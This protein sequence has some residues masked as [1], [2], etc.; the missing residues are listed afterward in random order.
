MATLLLWAQPLLWQ[1]FGFVF[2]LFLL[3]YGN[4]MKCL[5]T[6]TATCLFFWQ[7]L[8]KHTFYQID[9]SK[10]SN[11]V[12]FLKFYFL[13]EIVLRHIP[14]NETGLMNKNFNLCV[15]NENTGKE[16]L[17]GF[18]HTPITMQ[19]NII[20]LNLHLHHTLWLAKHCHMGWHT[21]SA[22]QQLPMFSLLIEYR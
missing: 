4:W 1:V 21:L 15:W 13:M 6:Y 5:K 22:V 2:N 18:R 8:R 16:C 11:L 9:V 3:L 12:T 19:L 20:I 17:W 14:S 10:Y 7:S